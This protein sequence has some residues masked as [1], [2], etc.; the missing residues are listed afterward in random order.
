MTS[1]L[2][3]NDTN[4]VICSVEDGVTVEE[5]TN[6]NNQKKIGLKHDA[7]GKFFFFYTDLTNDNTNIFDAIS[8][9]DDFESMKYTYTAEGGFVLNTKFITSNELDEDNKRTIIY[10]D[11]SKTIVSSSGDVEQVAAP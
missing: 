8:L 9:P 6:E 7:T 2:T 3:F 4:E 10:Q 1:I 5:H 11:G